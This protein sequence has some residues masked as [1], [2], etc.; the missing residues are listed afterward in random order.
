MMKELIQSIINST[1]F[2]VKV[3][4]VREIAGGSIN[5]SFYV[6]AGVKEF[7][8][9]LNKNASPDFF[10]R[11]SEGLTELKKSGSF[12][13]PQVIT[14]GEFE[15]TKF[16]LTEYITPSLS[17]HNYWD[18]AGRNLAKLHSVTSPVYGFHADNYIGALQQKNTTASNWID[19]FIRNR[20]EC[21]LDLAEKRTNITRIRTSF[22]KLFKIL[23]QRLNTEPASLLH[24]DLWSGNIIVDEKG[25][26][27]LV[28]P[29]VYFGNREVDLAMTTLFGGFEQEFYQSYQE[30]F[31][32][33]RGYKERFEIYN[34]YPLL[35]HY[36]LFGGS[37][38]SSVEG[39]VNKILR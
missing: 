16:L 17:A 33:E 35:V 18:L 15:E 31:P 27:C 8:I 22:E 30:V 28:D 19:F 34:L 38:L 12:R 5:R 7:F 13:I 6:K 11:E 39:T 26:P 23:P 37:Y 29:A 4:I 32:L 10:Q 25:E 20:I 24:G 2:T 21:Q 9:K 14:F 36:N 3:D 1:A